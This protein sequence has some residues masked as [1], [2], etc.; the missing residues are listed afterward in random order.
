MT[1]IFISYAKENRDQIRVLANAFQDIGWSVFWDR[2]IPTGLTW[3]GYVGKAL[4]EARCV[5]VAWTEASVASEWVLEEADYGK[6]KGNLIPVFLEGVDPP[7]GFGAFQALDLSGWDGKTDSQL[8]EQL[9][10]DMERLLK[11]SPTP[12]VEKNSRK[13][14]DERAGEAKRKAKEGEAKDVVE[15]KGKA[16]AAARQP[17]NSKKEARHQAKLSQEREKSR[18]AVDN[19]VTTSSKIRK[20]DEDE[21]S[22]PPSSWGGPFSYALFPRT[23]AAIVTVILVLSISYVFTILSRDENYYFERGTELEFRDNVEAIEAYQKAIELRPDFALAYEKMG[24]VLK[25]DKRYFEAIASFRMALKIDHSLLNSYFGLGHALRGTEDFDE[26]AVAFS[27]AAELDPNYE[28][29]NHWLGLALL[30]A[31]SYQEAI[32]VLREAVNVPT[33]AAD[34][35]FYLGVALLIEAEVYDEASE[36]LELAIKGYEN[37]RFN[38]NLK[39]AHFALGLALQETGRTEDAQHHLSLAM[40]HDYV[41]VENILTLEQ[42]GAIQRCLKESKDFAVTAE[43]CQE[44][45]DIKGARLKADRD[46]LSMIPRF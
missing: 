32:P 13:L 12:T 4:H 33:P 3:R 46:Y 17:P 2:T 18:G 16:M 38:A 9:V 1:D 5:V 26:A 29:A 39:D 44:K 27:K 20:A 41:V 36:N 31:G 11:S 35:Y 34:D 23:Y 21:Q 24:Y 30:E 6:K 15:I 19:Q 43:T 28:F 14:E 7:L 8:F 25:Y 22:A 37:T 10:H 40:P 45:L 42:G